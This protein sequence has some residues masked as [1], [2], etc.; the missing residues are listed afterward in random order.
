MVI[1][2]KERELIQ[3]LV[4]TLKKI[5]Q[6]NSKT[7]N[8]YDDLFWKINDTDFFIDYLEKHYTV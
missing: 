2:K 1:T 5:Y 7:K 6:S 3:K 8:V 4:P